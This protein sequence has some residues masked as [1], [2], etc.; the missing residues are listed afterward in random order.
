MRNRWLVG[1]CCAAAMLAVGLSYL[2]QYQSTEEAVETNSQ[3]AAV[4]G[5]AKKAVEEPLLSPTITKEPEESLTPV[6]TQEDTQESLNPQINQ[7]EEEIVDTSEQN[8]EEQ[9]TTADI[10]TITYTIQR[11]DTLT[12]ICQKRYG[13]ISKIDEIC[14]LNGISP[15]DIIYAG[16]K[17]LL[18]ES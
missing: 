1:A 16:G 11:G 7:Q 14:R 3:Y 9:Q 10:K 4:T 5:E 12:S 2:K 13:T 8:N 15:E 6:P 18:P 17:L